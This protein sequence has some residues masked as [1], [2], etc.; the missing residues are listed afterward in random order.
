MACPNQIDITCHKDPMEHL[1]LWLV[2]PRWTSG[3]CSCIWATANKSSWGHEAMI[4]VHLWVG[5]F[6]NWFQSY[7]WHELIFQ[8]PSMYLTIS[9]F[10]SD[11]SWYIKRCSQVL[12]RSFIIHFH[13]VIILSWS[14]NITTTLPWIIL[15]TAKH[16]LVYA[17]DIFSN[18]CQ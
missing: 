11:T 14:V 9:A 16:W 3:S 7:L 2:A 13:R 12:S 15:A 5:G 1:R 18:T 10:H 17:F 6:I 8:V 4:K